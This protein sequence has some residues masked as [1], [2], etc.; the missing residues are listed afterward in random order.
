M[1]PTLEDGTVLYGKKAAFEYYEQRKGF[2]QAIE[3]KVG[4]VEISYGGYAAGGF[5]DATLWCKITS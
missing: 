1:A 3:P 2:L 5:M 4:G